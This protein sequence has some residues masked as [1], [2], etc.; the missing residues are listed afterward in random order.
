MHSRRARH[1][2][3]AK[4]PKL[5]VGMRVVHPL[6]IQ[7]MRRSSPRLRTGFFWCASN[8]RPSWASLLNV[9][10]WSC[11]VGHRVVGVSST[12]QP[13]PSHVSG[14]CRT[15][16]SS[17]ACPPLSAFNA[18]I[19]AQHKSVLQH[20]YQHFVMF[21]ISNLTMGT[22]RLLPSIDYCKPAQRSIA[23]PAFPL[24][25]AVPAFPLPCRLQCKTSCAS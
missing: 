11:R 6:S 20:F 17:F 12:H 2:N 8:E 23:L 9:S 19:E 21:S 14:A 15:P 1:Q 24:S 22:G 10:E 16:S 4:L 18:F 7:L 3:G 5:G 25:Q 13:R